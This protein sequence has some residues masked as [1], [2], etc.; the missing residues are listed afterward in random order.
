MKCC[1][2]T[3]VA[4]VIGCMGMALWLGLFSVGCRQ[5]AAVAPT[6]KKAPSPKADNQDVVFMSQD[7]EE[8]HSAAQNGAVA[9]PAEFPAD[10]PIYPKA[11][12]VRW[13]KS[14]GNSTLRVASTTTDAAKEVETFYKQRLKKNRWKLDT[15]IKEPHYLKATKGNRTL[16]IDLLTRSETTINLTLTD[17]ANKP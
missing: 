12:V 9:L 6:D 16:E 10:V 7:G 17:T 3:Q 5:S 8:V 1:R 14:K 11:T 4:K 15:K 2:L 13:S